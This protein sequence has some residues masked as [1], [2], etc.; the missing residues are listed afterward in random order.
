VS[1]IKE[2]DAV[3]E[4]GFVVSWNITHAKYPYTDVEF[5]E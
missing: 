5:V 4:A 3:A 2:T 1:F